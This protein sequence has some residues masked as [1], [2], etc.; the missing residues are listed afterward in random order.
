MKKIVY[1]VT[2]LEEVLNYFNLADDAYNFAE[3]EVKRLRLYG[4]NSLSQQVKV[5]MLVRKV[6]VKDLKCFTQVANVLGETQAQKELFKVLNKCSFVDVDNIIQ[7]FLWDKTPQG[8]QFWMDVNKSMQ[9]LS[10]EAS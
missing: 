5:K 3:S 2:Y 8:Y 4:H 1:A 10:L 6:H 7:A 9:R